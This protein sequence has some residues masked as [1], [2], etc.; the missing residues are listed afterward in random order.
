[1]SQQAETLSETMPPIDIGAPQVLALQSVTYRYEGLEGVAEYQLGPL[2]LQIYPG[3]LLFITG[4][5][6]SGKT[7]LALMILGLYK[8]TTG[9][10]KLGDDLITDETRDLYRQ[11]FSAVFADPYIFESLLGYSSEVHHRNSEKLLELL[12]LTDTVSIQNGRFSTV[13]LSKGQ[14]KRLALLGAYLSDRPFY[15]FDEWAA[16]QDPDFRDVFYRDLLPNLKARGKTVIVITHDDQYFHLSDRL[17][18]LERGQVEICFPS[19]QAEHLRLG[20]VPSN[21]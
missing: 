19:A 6:G 10:L 2:D 8:P 15:L 20:S 3:E 16:E 18:R 17:L 13:D 11:N 4:G 12:K 21:A 5:N 9:T 14:R 7:T 1:V